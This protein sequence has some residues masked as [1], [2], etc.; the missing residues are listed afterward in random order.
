M[1]PYEHLRR[2]PLNVVLAHLGFEEFR[3]RKQGTE[4]YGFCP[5]HGSKKNTTCFSFHDDGRFNCFSCSAKGPG[6][7]DLVMQIQKT[8]FKGAVD[9]LQ[10]LHVTSAP[11]ASK[12]TLEPE[13]QTASPASENP[14]LK[15]MYEQ[16]Y[17]QSEW[18]AKRGL[19]AAVPAKFGVGQI[20]AR[21]FIRLIMVAEVGL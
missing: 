5:I 21:P 1:D 2:F 15:G 6:A 4:G 16:Y 11:V 8:G 14:P 7:V 9:V 13:P 19:L 10:E 17:V 3:Y 18:L 20:S 12:R